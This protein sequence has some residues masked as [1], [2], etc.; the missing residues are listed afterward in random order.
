MSVTVD[1]YRHVFLRGELLL[2]I[3]IDECLLLSIVIF[4]CSSEAELLLGIVI[5]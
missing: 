2:A 3:I 5:D 4:T 1:C